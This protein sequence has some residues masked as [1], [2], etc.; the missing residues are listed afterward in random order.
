[1]TERPTLLNLSQ[2]SHGAS[3]GV[4]RLDLDSTSKDL[5]PHQEANQNSQIPPSN[6]DCIVRL[7]A[8]TT[9]SM[10][11]HYESL[12]DRLRFSRPAWVWELQTS[13]RSQ[14]KVRSGLEDM[15]YRPD[16]YGRINLRIEAD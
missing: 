10:F 1:M 12:R 7:F 14:G 8:E 5:C 13:L 6:R 4:E 2:Q 9:S 15:I 3:P 11:F 16:L